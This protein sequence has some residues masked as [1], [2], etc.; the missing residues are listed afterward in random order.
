MKNEISTPNTNFS[1]NQAYKKAEECSV[2]IINY[3]NSK[4]L[5]TK[6][7]QTILPIFGQITR[8]ATSVAANLA[9][10]STPFITNKDRINK[11]LIA[12]KENLETIHWIQTLYD[13][14][15]FD[16]DLY[17]YLLD[18]YNQISKI[19]NKTIQTLRSK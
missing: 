6:D 10:G 4:K 12:Y 1:N 5:D 15:I 11:L 18:E 13:I 19:L 7:Y 16:Y 14:H 2:K 17:S 9:E 8:S 3:V